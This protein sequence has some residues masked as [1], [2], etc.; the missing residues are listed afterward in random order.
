MT[1]NFLNSH[2][3]LS[4]YFKYHIGIKNSSESNQ[5][6]FGVISVSSLALTL[7]LKSASNI[8]SWSLGLL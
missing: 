7:Q 4:D 2:I 1:A 8:L 3:I 5:S 6:C